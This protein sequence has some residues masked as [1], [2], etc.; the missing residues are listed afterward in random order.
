MA[1]RDL[2]HYRE[3]QAASGARCTGYPVKTLEHA[4]ALGDRNAGA[5]VLDFGERLSAA[6][7]GAHG[8]PAAARGILD[9]VVHQVGERL[10]QEECV[11]AHRRGREIEAEV[12]VARERLVHPCVRFTLDYRLEV[13]LRRVAARARLGARERGVRLES[14]ERRA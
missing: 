13:D 1:R 2:A 5:V 8:H 9:A 4:L 11:A 6:H 3:P 7:T 10:A 14:R 12:D